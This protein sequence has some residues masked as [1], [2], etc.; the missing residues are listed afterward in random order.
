MENDIR[1]TFDSEVESNEGYFDIF[2]KN[3]C[4]YPVMPKDEVILEVKYNNF[5]L[6]YIKD[7]IQ[8]VDKTEMSNSKYCM[9]RK[10]GMI[11]E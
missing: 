3:L 6:S 5:I 10:Y 7:V 4:I 1:I 2:D 9:A 8:C 11:G